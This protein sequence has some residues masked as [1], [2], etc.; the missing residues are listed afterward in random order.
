MCF[1][2]IY[3]RTIFFTDCDT[4]SKL[5]WNIFFKIFEIKISSFSLNLEK[6]INM[7]VK[8][9]WEFF[10]ILQIFSRSFK[11]LRTK[12]NLPVKTQQDNNKQMQ[13]S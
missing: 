13:L 5:S 12:L 11:L 9:I 1:V 8:I 3:S 2:V 6:K 4:F 10:Y 7:C